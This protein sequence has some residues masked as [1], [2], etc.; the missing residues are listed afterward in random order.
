[1]AFY[2]H[3][4]HEY[5]LVANP[6][7]LPK[8]ERLNSVKTFVENEYA[9]TIKQT[10]LVKDRLMVA[11]ASDRYSH[12][13][14]MVSH[15]QAMALQDKINQDRQALAYISGLSTSDYFALLAKKEETELSEHIGNCY[16]RIGEATEKLIKLENNQG[17]AAKF[18]K[19][20]GKLDGKIAE[21][22][23]QYEQANNEVIVAQEALTEWKGLD[24]E[25]KQDYLLGRF[26]RE[27]LIELDVKGLKE[28]AE[29]NA[30]IASFIQGAQHNVLTTPQQ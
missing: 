30:E 3:K 11:G 29:E 16:G 21:V 1:M 27:D 24:D 17:I 20:T 6:L 8:E 26:E 22:N 5:N 9:S 7:G 10:E 12:R 28:F 15:C 18:Y 2:K 25:A 13:S 23:E 14:P 4:L 19:L